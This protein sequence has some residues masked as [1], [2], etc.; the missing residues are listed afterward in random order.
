MIYNNN[1]IK[2]D[3]NPLN[4]LNFSCYNI[5][6]VVVKEN[7]ILRK[8]PIFIVVRRSYSYWLH[9]C[10]IEL[11]NLSIKVLC[12]ITAFSFAA[13]YCLAADIWILVVLLLNLYSA[14]VATHWFQAPLA[15]CRF[16][17]RFMVSVLVNK[18]IQHNFKL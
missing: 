16:L 18:C 11:I 6:F 15:R 5:I 13:L 8:G 12:F 10:S 7:K 17:Y 9:V 14:V 2:Q 4:G 3:Q 1:L